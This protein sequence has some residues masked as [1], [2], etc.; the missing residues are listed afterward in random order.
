VL[1]ALFGVLLGIQTDSIYSSPALRDFVGRAAIENRAPPPALAGYTADVESELALIL[2]DSLG[3]ELVG[4]LEQLA[5]QAHW[6]RSGLYELHVVGYR[7]QSAGAP[8]SALTFTRMYTVP[9]LYGNRLAFGMNDNI[10]WTK[11]D[12]TLSARRARRDTAAG[13]EAMRAVHPLSVDRETYY[14]FSG[15]DTVATLYVRDRPIRLV[16]VHVEPVRRPS[17]NFLAFRGEMD[18]DAERFQLV[19]MRGRLFS[20]TSA[21]DPLFARRVGAVA[22][23]YVEFENAE[24]NGQYWLPAF[25]RSE[26]Q[27][28]MAALGEIRPVYR[29]VSRFR[30][31]TT[32]D[33]IAVAASDTNAPLPP[34]RAKL[35]YASRDSVSRY[36]DWEE[37]LGSASA[38]VTTEDFNDLAPDVWKPT[39]RPRVDYWP[40]RL[41][42]VI[43][44][45]RVEGLFTG[46]STVL[47]LRDAAPGLTA[48]AT[49]GWAWT[50][51]AVRGSASLSY[52]P[53]RSK[54][55]SSVRVER[56]L[57]TTNDFLFALESGLSI[58]PLLSGVDD[59][60]YV[61]RRMA[62]LATTRVFRNVDRA[63]ITVQGAVVED[64]PEVQRVGTAPLF[65]GDFRPNR[66]AFAGRYGR[67]TVALEYHPRVSMESLSPGLGARLLYEV[68]AGDLDWQRVEAR[69]AARRY[70]H[71]FIL[72]SRLDAGA[73][74]ASIYPPQTLYELGGYATLPSYEYKEFGGDRAA[75]GSTSIAYQFPLWRTPRRIRWLV[76]PGLSP[77][78]TSGIRG[79]W[80]EASS[81]AARQALFALGGDGVTPLSRPTDRIR[82]IADVRLTVLS[83]ALGFGISRPIDHAGR[84]K[85]YF[86]WGSAF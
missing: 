36:G 81:D 29:L 40:S 80:T 68:A 54:W 83:G 49:A 55:I 78:I 52:A 79:G 1:L 70:W 66:I 64:R 25:Q 3:R 4:Q 11:R 86:A 51:N 32:T 15:G 9:T 58:G 74:F 57:A 59:A 31:Y 5:A 20:I 61:D 65:G 17:S 6:E 43:R 19:R 23:A 62:A 45:N 21:K 47:R 71:S 28:Q 38:R 22:V 44:Y 34:T 35:T 77:G 84:W 37:G 7:S 82:A 53:P 26:F 30:N 16:R 75:L 73:V 72:A 14:T 10:P 67:G 12:S 56:T 50:E 39:G 60:D 33:S 13:R 69:L 46:A 76:I 41:E 8:Y 24:V 2:R 85:P 48:R 18:F 63:L 27:A 42:D